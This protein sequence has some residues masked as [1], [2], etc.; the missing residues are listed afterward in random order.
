MK[1]PDEKRLM[2][3]G[4]LKRHMNDYYKRDRHYVKDDR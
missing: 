3:Y 1:T 2:S 4:K